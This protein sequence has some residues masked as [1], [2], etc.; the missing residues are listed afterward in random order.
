MAE[1]KG[2]VARM[3]VTTNEYRHDCKVVIMMVGSPT[4]YEG[5]TVAATKEQKNLMLL[6]VAGDEISFEFTQDFND[7]VSQFQNH[8][9]Q[10]MTE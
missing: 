4:I 9:L 6:T 5:N 8:T 3:H 10:D 1:I 7:Y 2:K